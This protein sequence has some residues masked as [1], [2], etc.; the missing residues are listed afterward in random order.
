MRSAEL[1]RKLRKLAK[2]REI[3]LQIRP[4]KGSH[5]KVYFGNRYSII[6]LHGTELPT[7]TFRKILKDLGVNEEE[8]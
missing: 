8:L 4:A 1:L 3:D 6:P 2:A 5:Q 7:G